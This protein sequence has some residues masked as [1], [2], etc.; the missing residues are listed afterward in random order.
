M[1]LHRLSKHCIPPLNPV[2]LT[3]QNG[4][5]LVFRATNLPY[6]RSTLATSFGAEGTRPTI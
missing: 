6:Q 5:D 2:K 3:I 4:D 1:I